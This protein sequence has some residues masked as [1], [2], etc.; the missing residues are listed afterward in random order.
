MH[1][2]D[3]VTR[4]QH[5]LTAPLPGAAAHAIVEPRPPRARADTP[6][7]SLRDA[8]GLAILFPI[9]GRTH[10][11]LTLRHARLG[12][13]AGQVSLPGG[14]VDP[15]ETVEQAALREARE[16]IGL[17]GADVRILGRLS[18]VDIA[19][20]GFR[21]HPVVAAAAERPALAP[22][23]SEVAR[24][25]EVPFA[26]LVDPTRLVLTERRRG[27]LRVEAPAFRTRGGDVW[28]ATAMVL[29][30]LLVLAGWTARRP[31]RS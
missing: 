20:T 8:A 26:D 9:A 11:V 12:R 25:F 3:L 15:G 16:E 14:V 17:N 13:H 18:P 5:A 30:E 6:N 1:F 24:I 19:V 31:D 22:A 4:L 29:A 10:L 28:G 2:T 27:D 21:L 7:A 23:H